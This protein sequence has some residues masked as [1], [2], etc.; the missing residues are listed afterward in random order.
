MR[1]LRDSRPPVLAS[2]AAASV[3]RQGRKAN[4]PTDRGPAARLLPKPRLQAPGR[5][6]PGRGARLTASRGPANSRRA[7]RSPLR[8]QPGAHRQNKPG[9]GAA[10]AARIRPGRDWPRAAAPGPQ[11]P[12]P[13]GGS[14]SQRR[15]GRCASAGHLGTGPPSETWPLR[16]RRAPRPGAG[17]CAGWREE[18]PLALGPGPGPGPLRAPGEGRQSWPRARSLTRRDG[19]QLR[20]AHRRSAATSA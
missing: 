16:G 12:A 8:R 3:R 17:K 19:P 10:A 13:L 5:P 18:T 2:T 11:R 1:T 7:R 14:A 9:A 20:R 4:V 15:P 6:A